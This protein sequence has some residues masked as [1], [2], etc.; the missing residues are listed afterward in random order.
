M[1]KQQVLLEEDLKR[2]KHKIK[3]QYS[4]E[5][6]AD[7]AELESELN[8]KERENME[9]AKFSGKA[10]F[11][12]EGETMSKYYFGLNKNKKGNNVIDCLPMRVIK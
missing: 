6:M 2:S 8:K 11:R 7:I 9:K 5:T 1:K 10:K 12:V 3:V 4:N